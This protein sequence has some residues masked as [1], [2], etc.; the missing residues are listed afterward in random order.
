MQFMEANITLGN[1]RGMSR[2]S[3]QAAFQREVL[4]PS[5]NKIS[6]FKLHSLQ[7]HFFTHVCTHKLATRRK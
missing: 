3:V 5:E 4:R 1:N 6:G 7:T 2:G